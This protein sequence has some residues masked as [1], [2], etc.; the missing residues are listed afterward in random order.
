MM[1]V[2][3]GNTHNDTAVSYGAK[4]YSADLIFYDILCDKWIEGS[5]IYT[6]KDDIDADLARFG[7][8]AVNRNGTLLIHA[9]F[10][11][12]KTI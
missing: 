2:F 4:C 8:S 7:H 1:L 11:G 6:K 12:I 3:G 5:Q 9:G 10:H